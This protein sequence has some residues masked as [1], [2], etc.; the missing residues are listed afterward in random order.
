MIIDPDTVPFVKRSN[1][2]AS[3]TV[4]SLVILIYYSPRKDTN[5]EL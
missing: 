2:F 4:K 1:A 5:D 3:A